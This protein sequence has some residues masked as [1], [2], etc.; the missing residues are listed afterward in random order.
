QKQIDKAQQ[1]LEQGSSK[2][3]DAKID[4]LRAYLEACGGKTNAAVERLEKI[5]AADEP[6]ALYVLGNIYLHRAGEA[7]DAGKKDR[8]G[9]YLQQAAGAFKNA[10]GNKE[11][12]VPDDCGLLMRCAEFA[13]SPEHHAEELAGLY[14]DFMK[15]NGLRKNHWM[16]WNI[17]LAQF[18]TGTPAKAAKAGED[19][20]ALL[21]ET[22]K[23]DDAAIAPLSQTAASICGEVSNANYGN[24]LL[25][26]L[27]HLA[28]RNEQAAVKRFNRLGIAA[29]NRMLYLNASEDAG[30]QLRQNIVRLAKMDPANTAII[31]LGA[32][33]ALDVKD[34]ATAAAT[35]EQA[36][37]ETDFELQLCAA[38]KSLL[39][40]KTSPEITAAPAAGAA[41]E[42]VQ[43]HRLLQAV[44]AFANDKKEAGYEALVAAMKISAEAVA[45]IIN[46]EKFLP[47]LCAFSTKTGAVPAPLIE[48]V[49]KIM[50][51]EMRGRQAYTVARCAAAIGETEEACRLW[52]KFLEKNKSTNGHE[53]QEYAKFLCHLAV[54]GRQA[55]NFASAQ[56]LRK[57]AKYAKREA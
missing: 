14:S 22:E 42:F 35:I 49:R 27:D 45:N 2:R 32:Y 23:I 29:A 56:M 17:A 40:G 48:G 25:K 26:L 15:Q 53:H 31:L 3:S 54:A 43:A 18:W 52:E 38:L 7:R 24:K 55:D 46:V 4:L 50:N 19:V 13:A 11:A 16:T 12:R 37:P 44:A 21:E 10:L 30:K 8:I 34:Q 6:R 36:K 51:A 20:L 41:D 57:A 39:A 1:Y 47:A 9:F 33:A 28:A 5:S